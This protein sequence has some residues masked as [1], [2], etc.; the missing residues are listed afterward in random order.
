[1]DARLREHDGLMR[2]LNDILDALARDPALWQDFNAL[3]DCGGRRAGTE[4]E[5]LGL[6]AAYARLAAIAPARAQRIPVPYAGWRNDRATLTRLDDGTALAANALL[7]AQPGALEAE[8]IDLGQG[9]PADFDAAG[10]AVRGR[11]ALVRHEYPF[12][13]DHVHRRK[14]LAM[15]MERGAVGYVIANPWPGG[16]LL[17]GSSGRGGAAGIP[18]IS[19]DFASAQRLAA[20]DGRRPRIRI[21]LVGED[22]AAQTDVL[23]LDLPAPSD[24]RVVLS[25]HVDGHDLA[26][27]ALDNATGVAVALALARAFAPHIRHCPRG[28]RVCLFSAEEWALAG[29]RVYLERMETGDRGKLAFNLNLDT[30]GGSPRLTALTSG[31]R[32]LPAFVRDAAATVGAGV[33]IHEPLMQSS[34]H[35]N[36]ARHGIPALRLVAGFND[37]ASRVR[38][39]RSAGDLRG[40]TDAA[41][42]AAAARTAA[43]LLWRALNATPAELAALR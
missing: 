28:L 19:T 38:N 1:M 9:R 41:E 5:R 7:G 24:E 37:D 25:A 39:I 16:G 12:A 23:V 31:F 2:M 8:V 10:D 42:L 11:I 14:K 30:V 3:C 34:D 35:Y 26:E 21:T 27:S 18:A 17:S 32:G 36:F 20:R 22:F 40:L 33:G 4:S 43:A 13:T 6:D 29:S 15:A